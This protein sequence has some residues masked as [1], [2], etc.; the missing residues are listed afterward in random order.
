MGNFE[1]VSRA[2]YPIFHKMK[3]WLLF[4]HQ[5]YFLKPTLILQMTRPLFD[6]FAIF[7]DMIFADFIL[8]VSDLTAQK[9]KFVILKTRFTQLKILC[10]ITLRKVFNR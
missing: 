2:E 6:V 3:F 7:I 4:L 9:M 10:C 5:S 1:L 8:V